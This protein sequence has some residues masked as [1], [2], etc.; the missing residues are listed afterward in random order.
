MEPA[1]LRVG[2]MIDGASVP[3]WIANVL[4]GIDACA[5]A[6]VVGFVLNAESR[7]RRGV[8]ERV[9]ANRSSLLYRLYSRIDARRFRTARNPF[10]QAD[11]SPRL[12]RVPVL[13]VTPIAPKPNEHRFDDEAIAELERWKLDVLLKFGFRTVRGAILTSARYGVWSYHHG[14]PDLYRGGPPL[15]WEI[16]DGARV[17]QSVLERITEEPEASDLIYRSISATDP[18]SLHRSRTRIYS[19]SAEFVVRNLRDVYRDGDLEV[20]DRDR[21]RLKPPAKHTPTNLQMLRFG[22]RVMIRLTRQKAREAVAHQQW[23][24]AYRRREAGLPTSATFR[25][26]TVLVPTRDRMFADPCLVDRC[27]SSYL[28]F[29]QL[30]FAE[31]KGVISCCELTPDGRTTPPEIVLERSYHLSYPYVFFVGEDA[32]MLPETGANRT[33]ELYKAESFPTDWRFQATLL[34][35]V[36]AVDP[37]LIEHDGLYWLFANVAVEEASRNDELSLF[38][39][40]SLLGPWEPHPR[41]PIVSDARC[42][43]PAGRPFLDDDGSLIR[44]SQDCSGGYGSAVVFNRVEELSGTEYRERSVGTLGT[45]W[46]PGNRGT[47]TYTRTEIWEAIDGRAWVSKRARVSFRG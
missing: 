5:S 36:W 46:Y 2:V 32:Y 24:V 44:P 39:A 27:S 25:G 29:E 1:P 13:R 11:L 18:I 35:G 4:D 26:A 14:D 12:G 30:I 8:I 28:F 41:N 15:F 17:S 16:Y 40:E 47:H 42:A 10:D 45:Q 19:T 6:E 43:R 7:P 22:W 20:M 31:N 3:R 23:F 37:T 33:V 38:S 9:W 34:D 21:S